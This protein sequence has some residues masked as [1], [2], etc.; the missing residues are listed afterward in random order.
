MS[1]NE[2]FLEKIGVANATPITNNKNLNENEYR[3]HIKWMISKGIRWFHPTAVTGEGMAFGEKQYR[4]MLEI[5]LEETGDVAKVMAYPAGGTTDETLKLTQT[6]KEVGA[7]GA[8]IMM[9]PYFCGSDHDG[10]Y[11]HFSHIAESVSEFP[12]YLYNNPPRTG[13]NLPFDMVENLISKFDHIIGFKQVDLGL[14]S[15]T[16]NR[17]CERLQVMPGN[18]IS[19]LMTM[20][21]GCKSI[22]SLFGNVIPEELT[23]IYDFFQKGEIEKARKEYFRIYPLFELLKLADPPSIVKYILKR[24]DWDFGEAFYPSHPLPDKKAHLVDQV[25]RNLNLT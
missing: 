23:R 3:R 20:G 11:L 1:K 8:I 15:D 4:R 19:L 10:I 16:Y 14:L 25:L 24:L 2:N 5:C 18:E 21:L 9:T 12:I 7:H 13:V 17:F 22:I 6:A